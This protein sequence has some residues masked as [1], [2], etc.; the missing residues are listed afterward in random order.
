MVFGVDGRVL[1]LDVTIVADN[2]SPVNPY[3]KQVAYYKTTDI[4]DW[5]TANYPGRSMEFGAVVFN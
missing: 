1:I 5:I 4:I 2:C 3:E